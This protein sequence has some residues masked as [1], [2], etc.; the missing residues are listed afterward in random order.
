MNAAWL[1]DDMARR[2]RQRNAIHRLCGRREEPEGVEVTARDRTTL[3]K[4]VH[5]F[6]RQPQR[7]ANLRARLDEFTPAG[8]D[9]GLIFAT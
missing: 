9:P 8:M 4:L 3:H 2:P 1:L 7:E 6:L 5:L